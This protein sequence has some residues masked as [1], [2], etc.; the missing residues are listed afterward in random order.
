MKQITL[1]FIVLLIGQVGFAKK[2]HFRVDMTGQVKSPNGI[3]VM[4]D[5][6]SVAGFGADWTPNTC[7]MTQ[8]AVDTNLYHFSTDLPAFA[9]YE[10][11]YINGDQS[12]EVEVVPL[13]TQVGYNFDDNR[14]IYIDSLNADTMHF[15]PVL[16]GANAPAGLKSIRFLVDLTSEPYDANGVHVAGS[17]QGND[18]ATHR[19]YSFGNNV[20]ELIAYVDTG[21][22][23]YKFYNG[24]TLSDAESVPTA[25]ASAGNRSI[26]VVN[27]VILSSVCFS[28]CS[29]CYPLS[30]ETLQLNS[31]VLLS[32]NPM[33][34]Y[35]ILSLANTNQYRNIAIVD[36]QGK[37]LRKYRQVS[38]TALRIERQE[39]LPGNYQL[40]IEDQH[41]QRRFEKLTVY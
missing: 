4:G 23:T 1:L 40:V 28:G 35:C 14:W 39:L 31:N 5:F 41:G 26:N 17:F 15:A 6:Q 32:P 29:S 2:V 12:Y 16:F 8:D 9:K 11:K 3:H 20:F 7:L 34:D 33:K 38:A 19:L 30:L 21:N 18:P 22:L 37:Y 25:C 36:M 24:N 13:E 27:D 10:F